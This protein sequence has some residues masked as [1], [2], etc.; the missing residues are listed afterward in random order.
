MREEKREGERHV[1]APP[2]RSAF[3]GVCVWGGASLKGGGWGSATCCRALI[4][5]GSRLLAQPLSEEKA[6]DSSWQ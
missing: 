2:A 6:S 3:S 4:V 5:K 1:C